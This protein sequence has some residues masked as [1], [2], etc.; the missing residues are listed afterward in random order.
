LANRRYSKASLHSFA[1]IEIN[2]QGTIRDLS[3]TALELLGSNSHSDLV[4]KNI[5]NLIPDYSLDAFF[6]SSRASDV[7]ILHSVDAVAFSSYT[8]END[9]VGIY[10]LVCKVNQL[11]QFFARI[12]RQDLSNEEISV[13]ESLFSVLEI[14]DDT[15]RTMTISGVAI[16]SEEMR[17]IIELIGRIADT[18][19]S[20]V[21][22]GE[23]GV[24]K[25]MFAKLI[26]ETSER[27]QMPFIEINCAAIQPGLIESELFGYEKGAFTGADM[28]GKVG[29]I[30][31]ADGGTLFLDEITEMSVDMQQKLLQVIQQK[32]IQRLGGTDYKDVN[33]R[34]I[35][36]TN[37][38]LS[39]L[40]ESGAFRKDLYY[41]INVIPIYVPPLR[42][43]EEDIV[44]LVWHFTAINNKKYNRRVTFSHEA[45]DA[46][47]HYSWPGNV[48]EIENLIERLVVICQ[49]DTI[50]L[51][52]LPE[53][54]TEDRNVELEENTLKDMLANYER[55]IIQNAFS[56]Y[57][58]SVLVGKKL[59][60]SQT[61]A[62][63]KIR[64]Y[65]F[66]GA[67]RI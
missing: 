31:L 62:A 13:I 47:C 50:R 23:T 29:K 60:I 16:E 26:H 17:H 41:R 15:L 54:I 45:V 9:D 5:V 6:L 1:I 64:K 32:R 19:A 58:T 38:E 37:R 66:N 2:N 39:R 53:C 57:K 56:M 34:L 48:R 14:R 35:T 4:G 44:R 20:V 30:E 33:F 3:A 40:V 52:D 55:T 36:A 8:L 42:G 25:S 46:L 11:S 61:G 24:G 51:E 27:K 65:I 10:V 22:I 59:G 63:A 49:Q 21:L 43:R 67:N 12:L 18:E 7:Q 28:K